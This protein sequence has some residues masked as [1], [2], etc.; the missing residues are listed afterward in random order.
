MGMLGLTD[1]II[2][3]DWSVGNPRHF[4]TYVG[5]KVSNIVDCIRFALILN[6]CRS[7]IPNSIPNSKELLIHSSYLTVQ[8]L[9]FAENYR[10]ELNSDLTTDAFITEMLHSLKRQTFANNNEQ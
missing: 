7:C 2:V 9:S 10:L 4:K 3:L 5:N 6:N 1:S 8:E